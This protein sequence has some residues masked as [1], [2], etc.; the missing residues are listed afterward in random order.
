M[1]GSEN[2]FR[3]GVALVAVDCARGQFLCLPCAA[4]DDDERHIADYKARQAKIWSATNDMTPEETRDELVDMV[5]AINKIKATRGS[6]KRVKLDA[7]KLI[8][9]S[10]CDWHELCKQIHFDEFD[11]HVEKKQYPNIV[12]FIKEYGPALVRMCKDQFPQRGLCFRFMGKHFMEL[13]SSSEDENDGEG[14]SAHDYIC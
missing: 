13:S 10:S 3:E 7:N 11:D 14:T 2:V 8:S 1:V 4:D 9:L 12:E 6:H 5:W